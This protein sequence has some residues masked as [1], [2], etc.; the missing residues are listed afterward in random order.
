M[1]IQPNIFH[2]KE[3]GIMSQYQ[4]VVIVTTAH[5]IVAGTEVNSVLPEKLVSKK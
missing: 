5:Q 3:C 4:T 1:R 2:H